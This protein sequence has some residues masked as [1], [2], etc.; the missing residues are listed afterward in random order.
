MEKRVIVKGLRLHL[1]IVPGIS[2]VLEKLQFY[3][4]GQ[5]GA[6]VFGKDLFL[7]SWSGFHLEDG[8]L[9]TVS[10]DGETISILSPEE[11]FGTAD[12]IEVTLGF[13]RLGVASPPL[14][15]EKKTS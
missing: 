4:G 2:V 7:S 10:R 8:R 5:Q 9:L 15:G 1:G 14:C 13:E 3:G 11:G 6:T 12:R